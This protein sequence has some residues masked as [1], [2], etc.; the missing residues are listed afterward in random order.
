VVDHTV[1][2]RIHELEQELERS[3]RRLVVV[4]LHDH[5]TY[6]DHPLAA[7]KKRAAA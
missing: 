3:E 1:M 5:E 6:S 4:G 2:E 7:R